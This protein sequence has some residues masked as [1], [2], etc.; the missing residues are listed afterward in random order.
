M[1][2]GRLALA[3]LLAA[4]A[5]RRPPPG[6][7]GADSTLSATLDRLP[8]GARLDPAGAVTDVGPLPLAMVPAPDGQHLVL[9][10]GGWRM[11]GVQVVSRRTGAVVQTLEQ[12]AA[13]L[14]L[15]FSPDGRTLY[16]SGG[17]QDVVYRYGWRGGR[18]ERRDSL[19]LAPKDSGRDGTRYPAGL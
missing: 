17:N 4:L 11:Q 16:A 13:F 18:A 14:G 10:L 8:T 12:P 7:A 15:A 19:V 3:A 5:C 9:S 1:R 6:A 2:H